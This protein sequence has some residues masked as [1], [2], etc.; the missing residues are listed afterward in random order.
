MNQLW[1]MVGT[2]SVY[3]MPVAGLTAVRMVKRYIDM[4]API[5]PKKTSQ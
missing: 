2:G 5:T 4:S 3:R 1:G